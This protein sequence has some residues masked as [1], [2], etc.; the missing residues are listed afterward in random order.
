MIEE[1]TSF[2]IKKIFGDDLKPSTYKILYDLILDLQKQ[3]NKMGIDNDTFKAQLRATITD[4]IKAELESLLATNQ[5]QTIINNSLTD[6]FREVIEARKGFET[7]GKRLDDFN[8]QLDNKAYKVF[9]TPEEF[10]ARRDGKTDDSNSIQLAVNYC[11]NKILENI[12]SAFP[13]SFCIKFSTGT[14]RITKPIKI[15]EA[16]D[17]VGNGFSTNI[18]LDGNAGFH[19]VS[20]HNNWPLNGNKGDS[21]NVLE[22]W[23]VYGG[24]IKGFRFYSNR[25]INIDS[26]IKLGNY[27]HVSLSDLWFWG[28]KGKCIEMQ[29]VREQTIDNIWCRYC[30]KVGVGNIECIEPLPS[31][32]TTNLGLCTNWNIVDAYGNS[33]KFVGG[34]LRLHNFCIHGYHQGAIPSHNKMFPHE[35]FEIGGAIIDLE[36]SSLQISKGSIVYGRDGEGFYKLNNSRIETRNIDISGFFSET[37]VETNFIYDLYNNSTVDTIDCNIAGVSGGNVVRKDSTNNKIIGTFKSRNGLEKLNIDVVN[38]NYC[39][40]IELNGEYEKAIIIKPFIGDISKEYI[41]ESNV[42]FNNNSTINA[43]FILKN[44]NNKDLIRTG[45][46][47]INPSEGIIQITNDTFLRLGRCTSNNSIQYSN[48]IWIEDGLVKVNINGVVKT[49]AFS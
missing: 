31:Q 46:S 48:C 45:A 12:N 10:G 15:K 3:F 40:I 39:N 17:F 14:Y 7:L 27:D 32:E 37:N 49:L 6:K 24:S 28:I 29:T 22:G 35:N 30:G 5:L 4:K 21:I 9:I 47:A 23:Q 16:L 19:F 8:S 2:E 38:K 33:I 11:E 43:N 20:V 44:N 42:D 1:L 25:H 34:Q 18:F 26:C 36:N 41:K 13:I